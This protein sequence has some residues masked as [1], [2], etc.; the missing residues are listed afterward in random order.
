MVRQIALLLARSAWFRK[1]LL[2]LPLLRDLAGRFV[3]GEDLAAGLAAARG[4]QARGLKASLNYFGMHAETAE[5]AGHAVS[6]AIRALEAIRAEGLD[7]HISVKLTKLGYDLDPAA[8]EAGL[9]RILDCAAATGGFVRLDMEEAVYVEDTLRI[10]LNLH[11]RYGPGTV[12]LVSQ[13]YLRHRRQDLDRLMD[14]GARIRLVKGGYREAP[15]LVFRL[16]AETDAAFREDIVRLLERGNH[17]AIATHDPEA[18]AWTR[19]VQARLGL[20]PEAFE[21]QM[22][23]GVK[24]DLQ[25]RLRDE[26]YT[27]RCY[28]PYGGDWATHL[29]GCLRRLPAGLLGRL[30]PRR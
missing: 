13:S 8:A 27:V 2:G 7:S 23:Y 5:E 24:P 10:F 30:R 20:G 22:L 21:F 6:E 1:T 28:V 14:C 17:P 29:V 26:G 25:A 12:G 9:R 11:A 4:L 19:A 15:G 18:V 16:G 3:G